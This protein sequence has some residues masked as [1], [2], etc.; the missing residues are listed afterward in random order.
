MVGYKYLRPVAL[1]VLGADE[2]DIN[3]VPFAQQAVPKGGD[4]V[5]QVP[6]PVNE[7]RKYSRRPQNDGKQGDGC[8]EPES[9][10]KRH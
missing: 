4:I 9:M 3:P 7:G 2:F 6:G 5:G 8:P 1:D 10:V